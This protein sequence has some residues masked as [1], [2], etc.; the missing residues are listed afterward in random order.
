MIR[1]GFAGA[2]GT[3]SEAELSELRSHYAL[4]NVVRLPGFLDPELVA[5][6][7]RRLRGCEFVSFH[8]TNG[9]DRRE[10]PKNPAT[11]GFLWLMF[12]DRRLFDFVEA[13]TGAGPIDATTGGIYRQ[14][15]IARHKLAWHRDL[16]FG[17]RVASMTVN[18]SPR[19][20]RGGVL[21]FRTTTG[22]RPL[23]EVTYGG[24][25][26]AVLFRVGEDIQH[27]STRVEGA[28]PKTIYSCWFGKSGPDGVHGSAS[29]TPR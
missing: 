6:V 22:H 15:S 27:R 5:R 18:L 29:R 24:A 3:V 7:Q 11:R 2:A 26:D 4:R 20:F 19:P 16:D 17:R 14:R 8:T 9:I 1:L 12:N 28:Q 13:V 25:G 10:T 23:G 21:Q